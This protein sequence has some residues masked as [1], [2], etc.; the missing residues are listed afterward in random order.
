VTCSFPLVR[1]KEGPMGTRRPGGGGCQNP[2]V[3]VHHPCPIL[4]SVAMS[5][6]HGSFE[7]C[8]ADGPGLRT[9]CSC[10]DEHDG[11]G[12]AGRQA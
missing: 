11:S 6:H 9:P 7:V 2:R 10:H 8:R 5:H 1:V 3:K 4:A 12:A